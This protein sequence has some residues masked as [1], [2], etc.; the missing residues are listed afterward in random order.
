[1]K[2][3]VEDGIFVVEGAFVFGRQAD[4]CGTGLLG[5][6]LIL[7]AFAR[8]SRRMGGMGPGLLHKINVTEVT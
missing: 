4:V 2:R 1:M 5:R 3:M 8:R 7:V 6:G